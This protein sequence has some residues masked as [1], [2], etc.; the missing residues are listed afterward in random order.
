MDPEVE[1]YKAVAQ[2]LLIRNSVCATPVECEDRNLLFVERLYVVW[3]P[4][5]WGDVAVYM[6]EC[7]DEKLVRQ[8]MYSFIVIQTASRSSNVTFRIYSSKYSEP[9]VLF[10]EITR[11]FTM[12]N[13][14]NNE[15]SEWSALQRVGFGLVSLL[16]LLLGPGIVAV[17][18]SRFVGMDLALR[19]FP[20]S[21]LAR[22]DY[23][24]NKWASRMAVAFIPYWVLTALS[25]ATGWEQFRWPLLFGG[26]AFLLFGFIGIR[27]IRRSA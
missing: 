21:S 13:A 11:K 17:Q 18:F 12:G 14:T 3:D 24:T 23:E 5:K 2:G 8:M 27:S 19:G 6:Y 4:A 25:W 10:D 26:M 22:T 15:W 7:R 1:T 16:G 9:K 20:S